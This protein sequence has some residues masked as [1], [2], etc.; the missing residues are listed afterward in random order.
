MTST[1]VSPYSFD[2]RPIQDYPRLDDRA[3]RLTNEW[4]E[5]KQLAKNS[6]LFQIKIQF[7][8]ELY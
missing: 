6:L 1:E 8:H 7:R 3:S 2:K 5:D 4:Y